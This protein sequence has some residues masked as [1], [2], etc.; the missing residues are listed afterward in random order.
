MLELGHLGENVRDGGQSEVTQTVVAEVK[1]AEMGDA[2]QGGGEAVGAGVGD[3][4]GRE[5]EEFHVEEVLEVVKQSN[6]S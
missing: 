6:H 1:V 2:E 5:V 3:E 4:V